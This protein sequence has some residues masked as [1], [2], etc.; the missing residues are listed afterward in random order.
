MLKNLRSR[1]LWLWL[2]VIPAFAAVLILAV[3]AEKP[4]AECCETCDS[5]CDQG[6]NPDDSGNPGPNPNPV[7]SCDTAQCDTTGPGPNPVDSTPA[8]CGV[9]SG[10]DFTENISGL[11]IN[12]VFVKCGTKRIGCTNEP[13]R[14]DERYAH[15]VNLSSYYIGKYPVTQRQWEALMGTNPSGFIGDDQPVETV[16]W[17]DAQAFINKLNERSSRKKYRLPTNAEW[18]YAARG[19]VKSNDYR[20]PGSNNV[21]DVAWHSGNS[22]SK[23]HPA[24]AKLPNELGLYD[25][26]GNVFE[27]VSDWYADGYGRGPFT[28][29]EGPDSGSGRVVRGGSWAQ[30]TSYCRVASRTRQPPTYKGTLVGF[31]LALTAE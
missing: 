25:M 18:E 19:G 26:G 14:N 29:P 28:N 15:T 30:D 17:D 23:T 11:N 1:P 4:T 8:F 31:R 13:C 5:L 2:A 12:M 27:W 24:G 22:D 7:D 6:S 3:C 21:D 20:Y 9:T 16:S 10:A